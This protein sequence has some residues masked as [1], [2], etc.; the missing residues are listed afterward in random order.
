VNPYNTGKIYTNLKDDNILV[1][2]DVWF[3]LH[4]MNCEMSCSLY[5][6]HD[7]KYY[8]ILFKR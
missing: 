6:D 8:Y 3:I 7:D 2:E 1:A 5:Y 4:Y